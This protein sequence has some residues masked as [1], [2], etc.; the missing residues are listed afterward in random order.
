MTRHLPDHARGLLARLEG[1]RHGENKWMALCPAHDD[2]EPSLA[3]KLEGGR[4]LVHCF[5]GCAVADVMRAID[6]P[7][8]HLRG[9]RPAVEAASGIAT[10]KTGHRSADDATRCLRERI[11]GTLTTYDYHGVD[12]THV[13]RTCRFDQ[14]DGKQVRPLAL[15]DGRWQLSAMPRPRPLYR[16]PD[17]LALPGEPV[18]VLE[19]EKCVEAAREL[20]LLATTSS[21]G[22]SAANLTDWSPLAER[23][24]V[25]IPDNDDAGEGYYQAVLDAL[26]SPTRGGRRRVLRL[27]G[28]SQRQDLVDWLEQRSDRDPGAAFL[29]LDSLLETEAHDVT[30]GRTAPPLAAVRSFADIEPEEVAWLWRHR[31]P[32]RRLTLLVGVPGGGKSFV[33]YDLAARV[34]RGN[35]MP[36]G[37]PS[38]TGDTILVSAEDDP[39]DTIRPRLDALGADVSRVHI[40]EGVNRGNGADDTPNPFT[41]RD[42]PALEDALCR[43]PETRLVVIDPIGSFLGERVNAYRDNEVRAVLAPLADL[44]RRRD[45][46]II[47]VAHRRKALAASADDTAL[48]SRA[49]TGI[50]RSVLHVMRSPSNPAHRLLLPGKNNLA[51]ETLGLSFSITGDPASIHWDAKP[52]RERADEILAREGGA[53]ARPG[54]AP[55]KRDA[56][57]EWLTEVLQNGPT[58]VAQ[59]QR[60]AHAAGLSW[61]TV[62]R[63][64]KAINAKTKKMDMDAGWCWALPEEEREADPT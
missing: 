4:L 29:E 34:S 31:I 18:F 10:A 6:L 63:A 40:L 22:S 38:L 61:S 13:G 17:L 26:G 52:V 39:A 7:M 8:A 5:A 37:S 3:V 41:L 30:P 11:R 48:G 27:P 23:D 45:V 60:E 49:F 24:I 51:A 32:L 47:L 54:P 35:V 56:A 43:H 44:A 15:R 46:A 20:G 2:N 62:Q 57:A 64:R 16:L 19:G 42:I 21:G 12:G 50:A 59:L 9:P 36:D 28:L 1:L 14:P 58:P 33:C 53:S 55:E 25:I